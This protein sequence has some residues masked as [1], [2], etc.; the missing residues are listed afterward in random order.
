MTSSVREMSPVVP[1]ELDTQDVES[2]KPVKPSKELS[3]REVLRKILPAAAGSFVEWYD[4]GIYSYIGS[5][6]TANF[7]EE[8]GGS[9]A[10]WAGFGVT[11]LFRPL[12]GVVIGWLADTF[13]RK[14]AMQIT[15]ATMLITSVLQGV[16]PSFI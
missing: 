4:F 12:G 10:T 14:R 5:Y 2:A 7:F 13:G 3:Q 8:M 11:F 15:I 16:L 6:V 9:I 1:R